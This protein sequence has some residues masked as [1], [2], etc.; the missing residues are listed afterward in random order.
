[1]AATTF[2]VLVPKDR[3]RANHN[4]SLVMKIERYVRREGSSEKHFLSSQMGFE[5][6]TIRTLVGFPNH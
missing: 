3:V 1:M 6:T 4:K 2:V 5:S